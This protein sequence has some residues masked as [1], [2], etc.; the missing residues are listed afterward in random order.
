MEGLLLEDVPQK[1]RCTKSAEI[2]L[3]GRLNPADLQDYPVK[4]ARV[5]F[6]SL[7]LGIFVDTCIKCV[8][9]RWKKPWLFVFALKKDVL[10]SDFAFL[11]D[12]SKKLKCILFPYE[13]ESSLSLHNYKN[14]LMIYTPGIH[15]F[16]ILKKHI[17]NLDPDS[18]SGYIEAMRPF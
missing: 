11:Q 16:P 2:L 14:I 7:S 1:L 4:A 18:I 13:E 3:P 6:C 15:I 12:F 5:E 8:P 9:R 10:L 17:T